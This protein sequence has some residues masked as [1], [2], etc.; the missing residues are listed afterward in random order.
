M[1]LACDPHPG[2]D[3]EPGRGARA[4]R[5]VRRRNARLAR[6]VDTAEAERD[7][8]RRRSERARVLE[9]HNERL[10]GVVVTLQES[11]TRHVRPNVAERV[12]AEVEGHI[13]ASPPREGE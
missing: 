8:L 9:N 5:G 12:W 13:P 4:D 6:Q 7:A 2:R 1:T 11:L 10:R 3:R